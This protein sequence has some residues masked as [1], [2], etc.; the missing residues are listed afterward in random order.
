[1]TA[2]K[3]TYIKL[4]CGMPDHPKVIGLSDAAFRLLIRCWDRCGGFLTDGGITPAWWAQQKAKA[5]T[6]LVAAGLVHLDGDEILVHD[7]LE[8]QHSR[9]EI[10]VLRIKRQVAGKQGGKAKANGVALARANEVASATANGVANAKQKPSHVDVD[11][12][13][14]KE[15]VQ[16][17]GARKRA[18]RLPLDWKP[19]DA[20]L[21]WATREGLR[22]FAVRRETEKFRDYFAG[23]PDS[24]GVKLDWSATW[25]NWLRRAMDGK[26]D[27]TTPAPVL[28]G[29]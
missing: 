11:V 7:Y 5:R 19:K 18:T 25:R 24:R 12:D 21:A 17:R 1:M 23:A 20:D 2:G 8:H 28:K 3:R 15:Q 14:D 13:V 4:Y 26:T 9:D 22:E 6:E 16:E 27:I 29:W 10:G